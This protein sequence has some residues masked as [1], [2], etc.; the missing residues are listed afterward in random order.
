L[1]DC[2]G[3][4][5]VQPVNGATAA[6]TFAPG[7]KAAH[8]GTKNASECLKSKRA[9]NIM[10]W[11]TVFAAKRTAKLGL[12][13]Y[14]WYVFNPSFDSTQAALCDTRTETLHAFL[15]YTDR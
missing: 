1:R 14:S 8:H 10:V 11:Y 15:L 6:P 7:I 13:W 4:E 3:S 2:A 12:V 5:S 9:N